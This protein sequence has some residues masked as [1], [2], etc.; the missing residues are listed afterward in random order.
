MSVA[1]A[2]EWAKMRANA[3]AL[4]ARIDGDAVLARQQRAKIVRAKAERVTKVSE[5]E[6][7][8]R[9]SCRRRKERRLPHAARRRRSRIRKGPTRRSSGYIGT[10]RGMARCCRNMSIISARSGRLV[11]ARPRK[12]A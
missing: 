4:L 3:E 1:R 7:R 6:L 8:E 5:D 12:G 9:L 2:I 10:A 11:F